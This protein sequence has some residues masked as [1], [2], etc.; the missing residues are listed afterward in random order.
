[1]TAPLFSK[2]R[3]GC[4]DLTSIDKMELYQ[5]ARPETAKNKKIL[6]VHGFAGSGENGTVRTMR[7]LLPGAEILAPDLPVDP[8]EALNLLEKLSSE[9]KPDIIIGTS[10]GA[11]YTEM[12]HGFDRI[13]V[14]P[15]FHLAETILKNNGLG[16]QDFHSPRADGQT[17][18]MVTKALL[19]RYREVSEGCFKT[20]DTEHVWGL[21]GR[22]D[23]QVDCF[24]EFALHY[25]RAIRFEGG[26]YLDDHT[27]LRSVLPVIQEI[28]DAQEGVEKRT[29]AV[30]SGTLA[31]DNGSIQAFEKLA[32]WYDMYVLVN[33]DPNHPEIF[34]EKTGWAA[35]HLGV[36]AWNKIICMNHKDLLMTDYLVD[37][38]PSSHG[39]DGF[40]GT[41]VRLGGETFKTWEDVLT[42]FERLGGQ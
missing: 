15:A 3:A 24:D 33:L 21:F 14:N 5:Y 2:A 8:G 34:A 29:V 27:F 4:G 31:E 35:L 19:E 22:H 20:C 7:L 26:H 23:D 40:M 36:L 11:M 41:A 25:P 13:L 37:R 1:M 38:D 9:K 6:Y 30:D 32:E 10:M 17:S 39:G 18:F 28:D 12:L 42:Y 16:K